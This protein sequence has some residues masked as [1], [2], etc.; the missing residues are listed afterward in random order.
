MSVMGTSTALLVASP[1]STPTLRTALARE[2]FDVLERPRPCQT[3]A[4]W[5]Q[6][7]ATVAVVACGLDDQSQALEVARALHAANPRLPIVF[8]AEVSSEEL[9]IA[10]LKA[11]VVDYC[12]GTIDPPAVAAAAR[13]AAGAAAPETE[14]GRGRPAMIGRSEAIRMV[15]AYL[16]R[17]GATDVNVL[18]TGE[19]GTGKELA[20]QLLH[21]HSGRRRGPF[22]SINCAAIPDSLLESELFGYERGAFTGANTVR[23]GH[24]RA[25]D[26]G[27][28]LLDEIGEMTPFAQ[29]KILRA[30]DAREIYRLG[31]TRRLPLNVRVIAATN[32]D[33][34]ALMEEGRFR[35]D[36]YYRLNVARV[37]LPPL[38]ER[39]EDIPALLDH[40]IRELN[41]RFH[42]SV[43]GFTSEAMRE[44]VAYDWPGN[45]REVKN[46]LEAA[47]AEMPDRSL[48]VIEVPAVL[49]DR[50]RVLRNAAPTE[51]DLL[52][53]ALRATRWNKSLAAQRL[54]WS[55]MTLYRK[56]AKYAL[57][58]PERDD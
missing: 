56:L 11:G 41:G 7:R 2:E 8:V 49:R 27:S 26:G 43:A 1:N 51:R 14:S 21:A 40:Y 19:T 15:R 23:D 16:E 32:Q 38:R 18:I 50:V 53:D 36:L 30:L 25:A 31:S 46:L 54:R 12:R 29:A 44:L 47:Y 33:L 13:A 35:R 45:I 4:A 5:H 17:V 9:V 20:A 57:I 42:R 37:R 24:L 28:A 39:R 10:A 58:T 34:D 3:G 48:K 22:V 55:R 52:L 6:C